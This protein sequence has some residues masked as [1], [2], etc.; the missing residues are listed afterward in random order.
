MFRFKKAFEVLIS[1]ALA[2]VSKEDN[3]TK[4]VLDR[5]AE[6][7]R[8]PALW[9]VYLEMV[10]IAMSFIREERTSDFPLHLSAVRSVLPFFC[11]TGH[12]QYLKRARMTIML[13]DSWNEKHPN[14]VE[15]FLTVG[16]HTVRYSGRNWA[17]QW[18]DLSIEESLMRET[19]SLGGVG[20]G[21]LR[22]EYSLET[23]F[24]FVDPTSCVSGQVEE[25][26]KFVSE[27]KAPDYTHPEKAKATR[28]RDVAAVGE[29]TKR[30]LAAEPFDPNRDPQE[31]VCTGSGLKDKS[32]ACN[33][34]TTR[35]FGE[36][37]LAELDGKPYLNSIPR[38]KRVQSLSTLKPC[39]KVGNR[40]IRSDQCGTLDLFNRLILIGDREMSIELC[41]EFELTQIPIEFVRRGRSH[42]R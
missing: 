12:H 35:E 10:A 21:T 40:S 11:S 23:R 28:N 3:L 18:S 32:G 15:S 27:R 7:G 25:Q 37:C 22:N 14:L 41:L 8:T 39:P 2:D 19:K 4:D 36:K 13:Y 29:I 31:L 26:M 6:R 42:E 34:K 5:L 17:G 30:L 16:N 33:P 20:H 9:V 24:H 1:K 38:A